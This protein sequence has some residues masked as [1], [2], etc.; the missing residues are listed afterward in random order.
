MTRVL[1]LAWAIVAGLAS[2][3]A[4]PAGLADCHDPHWIAAAYQKADFDCIVVGT[5]DF[6]IAGAAY[7]VRAVKDRATNN[8]EA[9]D[10]APLFLD[11]V[12]RAME[13]YAALG[14]KIG[15]V[16]LVFYPGRDAV[17]EMGSGRE[18]GAPVPQPMARA[19][20]YSPAECL[21]LLP[22]TGFTP[23][24]TRDYAPELR[25]TVAHEAAHCIQDW[26][27]QRQAIFLFAPGGWWTE[28]GADAFASAVFPLERLTRAFIADFDRQSAR[29][30][31]T[32]LAYETSP[33][34]MFLWRE[35]RDRFTALMHC[36]TTGQP[37]IGSDM[38]GD[39]LRATVGADA[40]RDF[41]IAYFDKAIMT[42]NGENAGVA[43][44]PGEA[45]EG[46]A[47]PLTLTAD[48]PVFALWRS[49]L[50]LGPGRWHLAVNDAG[51]AIAGARGP[52]GWSNPKD[53]SDIAVPCGA[54]VAILVF[55]MPAASTEQRF[56]ISAE[57]TADAACNG[58]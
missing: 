19:S 54:P 3:R 23:E 52:E 34:F 57:R 31:L 17:V 43:P 45:V 24:Q 36:V 25:F 8:P 20:V 55:A 46:Q 28:G 11:A 22:L 32:S 42:L 40:L 35:Q 5:R 14:F 50:S 29:T 37:G 49:R 44:A 7:H 41:A 1:F 13:A 4:E 48:A 6:E 51:P 33:F 15:H 30:P 47:G 56:T 10:Q 39:C 9:D 58:R 16:S 53:G 38:E 12:T 27:W 26:N 2:T 21:I 18:T